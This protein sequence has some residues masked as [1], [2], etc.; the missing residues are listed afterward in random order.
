MFISQAE[1]IL[2]G[3]SPVQ[4]QRLRRFMRLRFIQW[5]QHLTMRQWWVRMRV[6]TERALEKVADG[7]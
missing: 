4:A 7:G 5:W 3:V 6:W 2:R 1:A